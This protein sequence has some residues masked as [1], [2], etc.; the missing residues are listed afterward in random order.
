LKLLLEG[1]GWAL[2]RP[3]GTE[4]LARIYVE[5]SEQKESDRLV[6]AC[7]ALLK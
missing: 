6:A 7:E 2:F 5:A 3:S 1:G 4:P